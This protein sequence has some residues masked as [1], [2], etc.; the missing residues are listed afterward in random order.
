M[1]MTEILMLIPNLYVSNRAISY[2]TKIF[3]DLN[4]DKELDGLLSDGG[5]SGFL[6]PPENREYRCLPVCFCQYKETDYTSGGIE[7]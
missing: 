6:M 7:K 4:Q 3:R 1:D 5:Y 2:T